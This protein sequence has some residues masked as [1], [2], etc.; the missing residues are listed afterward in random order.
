[1]Y[2]S[3]EMYEVEQ[4]SIQEAER[5]LEMLEKKYGQPNRFGI[6]PHTSRQFTSPHQEVYKVQENEKGSRTPNIENSSSTS[7]VLN[8]SLKNCL[9]K[10]KA[11]TKTYIHLKRKM[12][13]EEKP[14]TQSVTD[15]K[16]HVCSICSKAFARKDKLKK[17]VTIHK[18]EQDHILCGKEKHLQQTLPDNTCIICNK[19][20]SNT[21]HLYRHRQIHTGEKPHQCII[22]NRAFQRKDNLRVHMKTVHAEDSKNKTL[23]INKPGQMTSLM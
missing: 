11:N 20:F 7:N 16:P 17:H 18:S 22:C 2:D 23:Q 19:T 6:Q 14:C 3:E 9:A 13:K 15:E 12:N 4:E 10:T 21:R 8:G 5:L 1:M